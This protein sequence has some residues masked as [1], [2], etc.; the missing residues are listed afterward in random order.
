MS[1][2]YPGV[3]IRATVADL[4]HID[5]GA[6]E[7]GEATVTFTLYDR[8]GAVVDT[9]SGTPDTDDWSFD[10]NLPATPGTYRLVAEAVLTDG[11]TTWKGREQIIVSR[12]P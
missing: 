1:T 8:T 9:G 12:L 3:T 4:T 7:M 6:I 11:T 2:Y 10:F 5:N